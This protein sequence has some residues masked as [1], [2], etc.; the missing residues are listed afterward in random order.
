MTKKMTL[1][2]AAHLST[3]TYKRLESPLAADGNVSSTQSVRGDLVH[4]AD[5]I[6]STT[7]SAP[8][9]GRSTSTKPGRT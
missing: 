1:A 8:A 7:V 9:V 5:G 2:I 6:F 4:R 3:A